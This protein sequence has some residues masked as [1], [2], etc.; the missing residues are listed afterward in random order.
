MAADPITRAEF[1]ATTKRL[2]QADTYNLLQLNNHIADYHR[3]AID[4]RGNVSEIDQKLD[5]LL[6]TQSS[7]KGRD[8]VI[9]VLI[10]ASVTVLTT[11]IAASILGVIH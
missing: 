7:I 2:D 4:I 10:M 1:D 11:V 5:K 3:E 9:F 6:E 8:G